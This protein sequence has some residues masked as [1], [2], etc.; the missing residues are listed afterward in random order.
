MYFNFFSLFLISILGISC[1]SIPSPNSGVPEG[2]WRGVLRIGGQGSTTNTTT[3]LNSKDIELKSGGP[4][5]NEIPFQFETVLNSKGEMDFY[6][7]NGNEK[8]KA[9]YFQFG[10]DKRQGK[11]TFRVEFG[12]YDTYLAGKMESGYLSGDW[13]NPGKNNA[14]IPFS[15]TFGKNHRFTDLIE[16][17]NFDPQ[18]K[19][20]ATM[21]LT[22]EKPYPAVGEFAKTKSGQLEGT[23]LTETGDF[24]YLAG[25]QVG[26]K[27][28]LSCFDG[29]HAYLFVGKF[30]T[31]DE[32]IGTFRSGMTYNSTW[33]AK[34][35]P[36][37][38]LKSGESIITIKNENSSI[39]D[40]LNFPS[41]N[42]L[43]IPKGKIRIFQMM[44]TWCPN[45]KD[46]S[47]FLQEYLD[48]NKPEDIEVYGLAFERPGPKEKIEAQLK[49]Y[50]S[51]MNI[52]YP[53]IHAGVAKKEEA[54]MVFSGLSGFEAFPT[55]VILDKN[56]SIKFVHSGFSGPATS[57]YGEWKELFNSK[58]KEIREK[59]A[60]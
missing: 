52:K 51:I 26:E 1:I 59:N 16:A 41:G 43:S 35:N 22:G 31:K 48:K 29:S 6:L 14:R 8:A 39:G 30:K 57:E 36:D 54:A 19:W 37:A 23:F 47:N 24:R 18:G 2:K 33:E 45:C 3:Q 21:D 34:R 50:A 58:I 44:G 5:E 10:F 12:E 7:I 40:N 9:S 60:D 15:A 13:V 53:I 11:D 46:E 49:R 27:I 56:N 17:N 4:D 25:D 32:L 28:Y 20:S 55:M 38:K 42:N